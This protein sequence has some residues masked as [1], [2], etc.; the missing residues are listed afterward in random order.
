[1]IKLPLFAAPLLLMILSVVCQAQPLTRRFVVEFEQKADA[2][3]QNVFIKPY[4]HTLSY[5]LSD[6]AHIHGYAGS[7]LPPDEKQGKPDGFELKPAIIESIAWPWLYATHLLVG[8]E[9]ILTTKSAPASSNSYSWLPLEVVVAV[10][11]LL[12]SYW[13]IDSSSSNLIAQKELCQDHPLTAVITV[14]GSGNARQQS[15]PSES[16]GQHAQETTARPAG[17]FNS[18]LYPDS[19]DGNGDPQQSLHSLDLNCFVSPCHGVCQ[20]RP[21]SDSSEPAECPMNTTEISTGHTG[22]SLEQSSCPH[23]YNGHCSECAGHMT[24]T[25]VLS[26]DG[27]A[28]PAVP[29]D[30][31]APL[32]TDPCPICLVHFHDH[33]AVPVIVKTQC[34]GKQF[35]LDCIS[36]CFVDQPIGSRRCAM[37]RQDPMPMLNEYTGESHPDTFFPDQAFYLA[38][39]EGDLDQ[40]ELSL[41]EGVNVNVVLDNDST[42]L[43]MASIQ[44]HKDIVERLINAGAEPNAA[45]SDGD[46]ALS[47]ATEMGNT[48]IVKLL[49][50]AEADLNARSED[51]YTPL[52]IAA[53]E[54][55]T[56]CVKVL[57]EAG[58]DLNTRT[59]DGAT[60][61]FIAVQVGNSDCVKV[62]INAGADVNAP[63]LNGLPP[64]YVAARK[65]NT[66]CVKVLIKAG[67]DI[68]AAMPDGATALLIAAQENNTDC[69]KILI[70]AGADLNA[71][72]SDGSTPLLTAVEWGNTDCVKALIEAKANLN[73]RTEYGYTPLFVAAQENYTDCVKVLIEAMA[74][75]NPRTK[76]GGTPLFI[77]AQKGNTDCVKVLI[78]AGA[79]LNTAM[80]DGA[81]PLLIAALKGR[82]DCVKLLINAGADLNAS[83][84]SD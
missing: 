84:T 59:Q 83:R 55:H 8:H 9:L 39:F 49:I 68:N 80:S 2:P 13:N 60:P 35:D 28:R 76:G 20:F 56:D 72:L 24:N 62:L 48:D 51:G 65:G 5:T 29:M 81:T 53:Q 18:F 21:L 38:C 73:A 50:D 70:D 64:L 26:M 74:D 32:E 63:L 19:T 33:D 71:A 57:I 25:D 52:F 3:N 10:G 31:D 16:S 36:K 47:I 4:Q 11:W 61:L 23:L 75:L 17:S 14:P 66:D 42:A 43:M 22:A 1:M 41:A 40:V 30:T 54:N 67:A 44:G 82:T 27:I 6:I 15:P 37:C 69:V 12:K 79:D 45:F 46:T 77:A 58:A 7:D 34:C 78:N